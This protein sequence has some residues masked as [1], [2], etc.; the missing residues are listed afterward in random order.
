[1]YNLIY[2][3]ALQKGGN[4]ISGTAHA[5]DNSKLTIATRAHLYDIQL[6]FPIITRGHNMCTLYNDGGTK[7]LAVTKYNNVQT[8]L[9]ISSNVHR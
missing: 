2:S 9:H 7:P 3:L 1:M 8:K 6:Q 5:Y 4:N